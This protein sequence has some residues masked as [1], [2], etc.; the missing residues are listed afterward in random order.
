MSHA[1]ARNRI[2]DAAQRLES[3]ASSYEHSI[4]DEETRERLEQL[5]AERE[6]VRALVWELFPEA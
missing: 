1:E 2:L 4:G 5:E 6:S 3:A